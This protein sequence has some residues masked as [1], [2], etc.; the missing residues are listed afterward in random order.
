MEDCC[1]VF[2]TCEIR[3]SRVWTVELIFSR[4]LSMMVFSVVRGLAGMDECVDCCGWMT[5]GGGDTGRLDLLGGGGVVGLDVGLGDDFVAEDA[6]RRGG[7]VVGNVV[8]LV[9]DVV[10][11]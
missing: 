8:G 2:S 9:V 6:G 3:L 7:E 1:W 5:D 10:V 4:S 11:R